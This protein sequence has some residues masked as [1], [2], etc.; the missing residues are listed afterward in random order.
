[1]IIGNVCLNVEEFA[2][3]TIHKRENNNK[4]YYVVRGWF[5]QREGFVN[6]YKANSFKEALKVLEE[7]NEMI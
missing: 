1:M 6:V 3:F 5:K 7:L 4:T 2:A